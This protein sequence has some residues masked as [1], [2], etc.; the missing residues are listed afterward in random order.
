VF[1]LHALLELVFCMTVCVVLCLH[2][3]NTEQCF[4]LS[5]LLLCVQ[6]RKFHHWKWSYLVI[7]FFYKLEIYRVYFLPK[8]VLLYWCIWLSWKAE[9]NV[10]LNTV[11]KKHTALLKFCFPSVTFWSTLQFLMLCC[12][13]FEVLTVVVI[14]YAFWVRTAYGVVHNHQCSGG[15]FCWSLQAIGRYRQYAL[16]KT[17]VPKNVITLFYNLEN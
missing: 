10:L 12:S 8:N 9:N 13:G 5:A 16:T 1:Y 7:Q 14:H 4:S 3:Y 15:P 2:L 6:G 11:S 17:S